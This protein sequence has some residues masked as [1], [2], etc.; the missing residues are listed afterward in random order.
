MAAIL[1]HDEIKK[2]FGH[3][4]KLYREQIKKGSTYKPYYRKIKHRGLRFPA[5]V[6]DLQKL[7]DQNPGLQICLYYPHGQDFFLGVKTKVNKKSD[8]EPIKTV[9][10]VFF[11]Y[12]NSQSL[13]I[14]GYIV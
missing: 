10:L 1:F 3:N 14:E 9:N 2:K 4:K 11:Q 7:S 13:E 6:N 5:T 12:R 8:E